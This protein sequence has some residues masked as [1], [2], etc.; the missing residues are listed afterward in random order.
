MNEENRAILDGLQK[1]QY[2]EFIRYALG[3]R[4]FLFEKDTEICAME[5]NTDEKESKESRG[6]PKVLAYKYKDGKKINTYFVEPEDYFQKTFRDHWQEVYSATDYFDVLGDDIVWFILMGIVGF[7]SRD[8][9]DDS[10][11][12]IDGLTIFNQNKP[13]IL[14]FIIGAG[15]NTGFGIGDWN[16]LI[17]AMRTSIRGLKGIPV[18][19]GTTPDYLKEFEEKMCN[20]NYIAPQILKDLDSKVYYHRLYENLYNSFNPAKTSKLLNASIVDTN[21]YQIARISASQKGDNSILTFNY[22]NVLELIFDNNFA[23]N[24]HT[25]YKKARKAPGAK[26]EIVH[27]HGYYPCMGPSAGPHYSIVLSCYE[28]M[29]GYM[30]AKT[31]A[32]RQLSEQ[33][34]KVNL[35]IGN[36]LSDY[37]EQKVFFTQHKKHLSKFNYLFLKSSDAANAWMDEY[38][39]VYYMKMGIIPVFFSDFKDMN[40][41]LKTL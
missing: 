34:K 5:K 21:L 19:G 27:S 38:R 39:T 15:V 13:K 32:R 22:D 20:T 14:N 8:R 2:Y 23:I 40:D 7:D 30:E 10:K 26:V 16:N 25:E 33:L 24:V 1:K 36:S 6:F 11:K 17:D 3:M 31:Y 18:P 29:D 35:I 9:K 12:R 41:F 37:E 28:Y 4:H